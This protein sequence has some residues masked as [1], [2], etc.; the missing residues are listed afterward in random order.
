MLFYYVN[1]YYIYFK[2]RIFLTA[3]NWF[4]VR[5]DA[6]QNHLGIPHGKKYAFLLYHPFMVIPFSPLRSPC[7]ARNLFGRK[8]P[9]HSLL[10]LW[11]SARHTNLCFTS[12]SVTPN[13]EIFNFGSELLG[14]GP[15]CINCSAQFTQAFPLHSAPHFPW[16]HVPLYRRR[17]AST[18]CP[19]P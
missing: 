17:Q 9:F 7:H 5:L 8:T 3:E 11:W 16:C 19:A 14:A 1:L 4:F 13:T 12:V 10:I 18:P 6:Q 15:Y 2:S